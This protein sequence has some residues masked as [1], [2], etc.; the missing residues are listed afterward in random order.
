MADWTTIRW[1]LGHHWKAVLAWGLGIGGALLLVFW[2]LRGPADAWVADYQ[3]FPE[4]E[5]TVVTH[6]FCRTTRSQPL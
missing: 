4:G 1:N 5:A 3:P 2:T 6:R